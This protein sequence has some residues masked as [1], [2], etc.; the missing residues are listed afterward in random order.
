M[1]ESSSS[2]ELKLLESSADDFGLYTND[3]FN[4]ADDQGNVLISTTF[5]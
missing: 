1:S 2:E 3:L 4:V 5:P